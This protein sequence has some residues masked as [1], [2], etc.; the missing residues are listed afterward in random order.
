MKFIDYTFFL[1]LIIIINIILFSNYLKISNFFG[2]YDLPNNKLKNH[3]KIAYPIGGIILYL[4]LLILFSLDFFLNNQNFFN[5][6][7]FDLILLFFI[8]TI[9]F[10]LGILDDKYD[11][12]YSKKFIFLTFFILIIL[13]VDN[14]LILK[15]L[16]LFILKKS[17]SVDIFQIFLTTLFIL[18]Y[19]NAFNMFD[20]INLQS[21][22]YSIT[23]LS[24]YYIGVSNA[25]VII[26]LIIFFFIFLF[27][28]QKKNVFLGNSGS[29]LISFLI[30][31]YF[32]KS[33]NLGH[34]NYSES[35][36][37]FMCIPGLDMFRLFI[38]RILKN[39]N[40]FKGDNNHLHHILLRN[41]GFIKTTIIIQFLIFSL[42]YISLFH[43]ILISIILS[44]ISY[45]FI[46]IIY[47]SRNN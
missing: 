44:L 41:V 17:I 47:R 7:K 16:R 40:P 20:G 34:I 26:P 19:L 39:K 18:L 10:L 22:I 43:S 21:G 2:I 28:N 4:N 23:V 37:I 27:F 36:Y 33:Y 13:F 1:L 24:F 29:L 25:F 11:L 31:Y 46:L 32:I 12:S 35:I 14:N 5:L 45:S 42:I 30:S 15:E 38:E 8:S 9:I 3:K 6:S